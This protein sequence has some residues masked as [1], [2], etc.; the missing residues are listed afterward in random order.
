MS[1]KR[2]FSTG[3]VA[4]TLAIPAVADAH[5]DTMDGP[6]I[7]AA[8]A[9]LASGDITPALIWIQ[10]A[11]DLEV[12]EAFAR[13]IEVRRLGDAARDVADRY[14]YETLVRLHRAGEGEAFTGIEPSGTDVGPIIPEA[15]RALVSGSI[16]SL[17]RMLS[18]DL[19]SG[20]RTRFDQVRTKQAAMREGDVASGRAFVKAYVEFMHYA[21]HLHAATVG[22]PE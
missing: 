22:S 4:L 18:A 21:E 9:A 2:G 8:Q 10:P 5:C 16:D 17:A 7:K 6:V 1:F 15:D 13:A 19:N 3:I 20:L 11:A 12:R 14:F